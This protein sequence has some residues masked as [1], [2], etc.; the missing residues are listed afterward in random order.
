VLFETTLRRFRLAAPPK[1]VRSS[2]HQLKTPLPTSEESKF[3]CSD[4]LKQDIDINEGA[5]ILL[6]KAWQCRSFF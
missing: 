5:I 4:E 3:E 6:N 2:P 1:S